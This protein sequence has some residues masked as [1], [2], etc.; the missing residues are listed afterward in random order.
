MTAP[1]R[2]QHGGPLT[3]SALCLG[4]GALVGVYGLGALVMGRAYLP[5]LWRPRWMVTGADGVALALVY[6]VLGLLLAFRWSFFRQYV[7]GVGLAVF[8]V[9]YGAYALLVGESYLPGLRGGTS[10]VTGTHGRGVAI[11]YLAGG[12]FLFSRF[13]AEQRVHREGNRAQLYFVQ[14][15]LLLVLIAALIYVLLNVGTAG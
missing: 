12:L 8:G 3:G 10:A 5:G 6:V 11:A 14:I 2:E 15:V 9:F 7:A 13:F 4:L 1:E